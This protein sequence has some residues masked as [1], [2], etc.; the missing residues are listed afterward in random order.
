MPCRD[1][2]QLLQQPPCRHSDDYTEAWREAED[3]GW[4]RT[5]ENQEA[6][7]QILIDRGVEMVYSTEEQLAELKAMNENT[8]WPKLISMGLSTQET[9]DLIRSYAK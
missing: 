8:I 6:N 7:L 9:V 3:D 2:Q 5:K 1:R 4:R